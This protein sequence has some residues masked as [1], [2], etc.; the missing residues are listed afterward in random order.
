[1]LFYRRSNEQRIPSYV[2]VNTKINGMRI[3]NGSSEGGEN[4]LKIYGD[5]ENTKKK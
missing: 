5:L 4:G 1:L 3:N 2:E